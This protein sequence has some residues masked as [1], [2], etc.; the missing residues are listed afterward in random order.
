MEMTGTTQGEGL[1]YYEKHF[2]ALGKESTTFRKEIW[3]FLQQ[4]AKR[5]KSKGPR[6]PRISKHVDLI[7]LFK[8]LLF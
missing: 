7:C 4:N 8:C 6:F 5:I 2:T 3:F 1:N